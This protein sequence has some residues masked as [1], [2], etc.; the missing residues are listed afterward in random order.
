VKTC[1]VPSMETWHGACISV[2]HAAG[3]PV[4]DRGEALLGAL[5]DVT[6]PMKVSEVHDA[7]GR[8]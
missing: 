5:F 6:N 2:N 8:G 7:C 1:L 3:T 4:A